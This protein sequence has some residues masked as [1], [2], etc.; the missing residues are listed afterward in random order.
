VVKIDRSLSLVKIDQPPSPFFHSARGCCGRSSQRRAFRGR[1]SR[2]ALGGKAPRTPRATLAC[3]PVAAV[4][5]TCSVRSPEAT[6]AR[7][8]FGPGSRGHRSRHA[9]GG[10]SARRTGAADDQRIQG[11]PARTEGGGACRGQGRVSRT[12]ADS[13]GLSLEQLRA[14][15]YK[16][17]ITYFIEYHAFNKLMDATTG[18]LLCIDKQD[19][20][21][22]GN[23]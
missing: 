8:E 20:E 15:V 13:R 19:H 11:R 1:R 21:V 7:R 18:V 16:C 10:R 5:V 9:G 23:F 14:S 12:L 6:R 22:Y 4:P 17:S 3:S 2:R